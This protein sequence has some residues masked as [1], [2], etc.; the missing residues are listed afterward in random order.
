MALLVE[1][2]SELLR[3]TLARPERRNAF[4]AGLIREL[5]EAFSD[6]GDARVVLLAGEGES[7][8]AGADVDWQ[9]ASIDLSLEENRQD[10]LRLY[11]M[12]AALDSCPAPVVARVQGYALG[13]GS[14][15]VACADVVV[16]A[17]DAT[18]GFTEVRLGI[19]PAVISPFV[20]ARIGPGAAR[21][22]FLTGE[23]FDANTAL[24]IGLV[25]EVAD[26][27]D[28]AVERLVGELLKSGPE[29]TRA[30]KRLVRERPETGE[31]LARIA[32]GLRA[33]DGR[34]ALRS[35]AGQPGRRRA[36]DDDPAVHGQGQGSSAVP[37][38]SADLSGAVPDAGAARP[39]RARPD[40]PPRHRASDYH[41]ELEGRGSGQPVLLARSCEARASG[42]G[43]APDGRRQDERTEHQGRDHGG[44]ALPAD[45]GRTVGEEHNV[46][47]DDLPGARPRARA[48]RPQPARP[49]AAPRS[50][51]PP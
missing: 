34:L 27:L 39:Q 47:P 7:F 50:R 28:R 18:F 24:R 44:P 37:V 8:C 11:E 48:A 30:A 41:G 16:A 5:T 22:F 17:P 35:H 12:L 6:V 45:C 9:R 2:D 19:I 23:R 43:Q 32:A 49:D 36:G 3:V 46:S 15:L 33:G 20:F 51:A 42:Q 40:R 14:G 26:D 10:A 31:E 29:A 38:G 1:R 21:R 25:H 13:G 4:D